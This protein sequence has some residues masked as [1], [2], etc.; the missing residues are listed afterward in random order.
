MKICIQD[1]ANDRVIVTDLPA[2]LADANPDEAMSAIYDA[3]G[4]SADDCLYQWGNLTLETAPLDS[5]TQNFEE[6]ARAA[7]AEAQDE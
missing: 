6:D 4:L 5:L 3:L 7:L 2:Y 1:H